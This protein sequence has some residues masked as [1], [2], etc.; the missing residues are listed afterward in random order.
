M[1]QKTLRHLY[2]HKPQFSSFTIQTVTGN[3]VKVLGKIDVCR[4]F[5]RTCVTGCPRV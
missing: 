1:K 5:R 2:N 3:P 4:C